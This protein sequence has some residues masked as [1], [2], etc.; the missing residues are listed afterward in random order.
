MQ[1]ARPGP[2]HRMSEEM[3]ERLP[4]RMSEH[5]YVR[6]YARNCQNRYQIECQKECQNS[7]SGWGS[8]EVMYFFPGM[9]TAMTDWFDFYLGMIS[10]LLRCETATH[11]RPEA[12]KVKLGTDVAAS[13]FYNVPSLPGTWVYSNTRSHGP[14]ESNGCRFRHVSRF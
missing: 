14:M 5:P 10:W 7:L 1:W 6:K 4:D 12:A 9:A 3:P 13:E 8:L 11:Q 2:K